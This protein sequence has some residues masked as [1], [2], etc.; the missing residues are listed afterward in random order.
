MESDGLNAAT[1]VSYQKKNAFCFSWKLHKF[2]QRVAKLFCR[3]T[4]LL[5]WTGL[6]HSGNTSAL[7][8]MFFHFVTQWWK[9]FTS[10]ELTRILTEERQHLQPWLRLLAAGSDECFVKYDFDRKDLSLRPIF[11]FAGAFIPGARGAFAVDLQC[12]ASRWT[13][14]KQWVRLRFAII[15]TKKW[16]SDRKQVSRP[17]SLG[18][19]V[20]A[21]TCNAFLFLP[22]RAHRLPRSSTWKTPDGQR[23]W[24]R[25]PKPW[26]GAPPCWRECGC[27]SRFCFASFVARPVVPESPY[28]WLK[29]LEVESCLA[30][31]K[32]Q[33]VSNKAPELNPF[34][35]I[36][37]IRCIL[38][39]KSTS[40]NTTHPQSWYLIQIEFLAKTVARRNKK[41][42]SKGT[43]Y[44]LWC[45]LV[46]PL[47]I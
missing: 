14:R 32:K 6:P 37:K 7:S 20:P 18:S 3:A 1:F 46:S 27:R 38:N 43:T 35:L 13:W 47:F 2:V 41:L 34:F 40:S 23:A 28:S 24:S 19:A 10:H 11:R 4:V 12:T 36:L 22:D 31:W 9:V 45:E 44:L 15:R 16:P 33:P 21:R 8:K 39:R 29:W 17:V 42:C 26:A 5:H 25:R 30:C